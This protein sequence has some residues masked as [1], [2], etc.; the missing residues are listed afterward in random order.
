MKWVFVYG[1]QHKWNVNKI[2]NSTVHKLKIKVKIVTKSYLKYI[3]MN[4]N[5]E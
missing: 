2:G 5:A 3:K 4:I 1:Y